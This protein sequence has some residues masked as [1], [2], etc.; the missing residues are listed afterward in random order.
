MLCMT[1]SYVQLCNPLDITIILGMFPADGCMEILNKIKT[2][3]G[4]MVADVIPEHLIV[5]C[6]IC[7]RKSCVR[8]RRERNISLDGDVSFFPQKV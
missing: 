2:E 5:L 4:R 3:N 1:T 7:G 8:L 6:H